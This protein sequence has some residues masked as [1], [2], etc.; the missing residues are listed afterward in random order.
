MKWVNE[1]L[2][3]WLFLALFML[4]FMV[5]KSFN[6]LISYY[7]LL[8]SLCTVLPCSFNQ[9]PLNHLLQ[10]RKVRP[11]YL[12]VSIAFLQKTDWK[13]ATKHTPLLQSEHFKLILYFVFSSLM[14]NASS[15]SCFAFILCLP[16][17]QHKIL[18]MCQRWDQQSISLTLWL[19]CQLQTVWPFKTLF[20]TFTCARS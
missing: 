9:H 4:C 8:P 2:D 6:N 7:C 11:F 5:W 3:H 19:I 20:W 17:Q 14:H 13:M 10:I 12:T 18:L 16:A 15:H 1:W